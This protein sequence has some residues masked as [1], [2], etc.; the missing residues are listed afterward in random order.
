[1]DH[2]D[3]SSTASTVSGIYR[4]ILQSPAPICMFYFAHPFGISSPK[5]NINENVTENYRQKVLNNENYINF[6]STKARERN[7]HPNYDEHRM[8]S[9]TPWP[10]DTWRR[11]YV[12]PPLV[13]LLAVQ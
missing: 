12:L 1:M 8:A 7:Y 2:D 10:R 11:D 13:Q 4:N 3:R 5:Q 9:Y 6:K